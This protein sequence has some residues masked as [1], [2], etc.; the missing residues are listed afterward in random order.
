MWL[1]DKKIYLSILQKKKIALQ[2][3]PRIVAKT[4]KEELFI[5]CWGIAD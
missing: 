1:K 2:T 5:L 4:L 3:I